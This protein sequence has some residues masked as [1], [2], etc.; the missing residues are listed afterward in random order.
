[1]PAQKKWS[2]TEDIIF[3]NRID[4]GERLAEQ[5]LKYKSKQPLLL[6]L[7]RGGVPV[8]YEVAKRLKAPLDTLVVRKIGAPSNAEFGLGAIAPG[9]VIVYDD[10]ALRSLG[11]ARKNLDSTL[12]RELREM[13]RRMVRY[14]SGDYSRGV[15]PDTVIIID[16]GLATG[17][18]ARAAVES[19]KL[20]EKPRKIIFA[21]PICAQD[22]ANVLR[23]L[24]DE[25]V[26]VSEVRDLSAIALWYH[27]FPQTTD[28]EVLD[29]LERAQALCL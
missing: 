8:A 11:L 10:A 18:S 16:D 14:R 5:L 1:M 21:A 3:E 20:R 7:P 24:V 9:D 19:V 12:E 26:C 15:T 25:V 23:N 17:V 6:A 4:A 29:C 2:M 27:D 13:D 28:E 22:S